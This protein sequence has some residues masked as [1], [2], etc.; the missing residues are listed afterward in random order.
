M[1]RNIIKT[2]ASVSASVF[3]KP[4]PFYRIPLPMTYDKLNSP[5]AKYMDIQITG[6]DKPNK[7]VCILTPTAEYIHDNDLYFMLMQEYKATKS[8]VIQMTAFANCSYLYIDTAKL[9]GNSFMLASV[10]L[11]V[12][13]ELIGINNSTAYLLLDTI[14][15]KP[16]VLYLVGNGA[17]LRSMAE[18]YIDMANNISDNGILNKYDAKRNALKSSISNYSK[19]IVLLQNYCRKYE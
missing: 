16:A 6:S 17:Y 5:L 18:Q 2:V 3:Y 14:I 10:T 13:T 12:A 8:Q 4:T 1:L 11:A 7:Y 19:R 15:L 9:Y